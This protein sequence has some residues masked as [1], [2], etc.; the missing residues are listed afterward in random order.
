MSIIHDNSTDTI[1][2]GGD[3][4][5]KRKGANALETPSDFASKS[6]QLT[7]GGITFPD[8]TVMTT[9]PVGGAGSVT[10][11][12]LYNNTARYAC[13]DVVGQSVWCTSTSTVHA[14]KTW[15]R[16]GTSLTINHTAHGHL[17][18]ERTI[19]RNTNV[20][21]LNALITAVTADTFTVTC[22]DSGATSGSA[23]AYLMGFTYAHNTKTAGSILGGTASAPVGCDCV[24]LSLHLNIGANQRSATTYYVKVPASA[25]NGAGES[26][27]V[28]NSNCPIVAVRQL[29]N[30]LL[31]ATAATLY[32]SL[33]STDNYVTYQ[34]A[35]MANIAVPQTVS[36]LF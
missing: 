2:F 8:N 17:V 34:M 16:S 1:T 22:A 36:M 19:I 31:T 23:A 29:T 32:L 12:E 3:T 7:D 27:T 4:Q 11:S 28:D 18:G 15:T 10:P 30:G 13:I 21:Y 35:A 14:N 25:I 20:F 9:A 33:P 24:M 5:L 26:T 6:L